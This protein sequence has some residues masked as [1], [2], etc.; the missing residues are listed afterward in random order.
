[1]PA[2][3]PLSTMPF[4]QES[5][6]VFLITDSLILI[7]LLHLTHVTLT[8]WYVGTYSGFNLTGFPPIVGS[9]L[10]WPHFGWVIAQIWTSLNGLI[11]KWHLLADR[12]KPSEEEIIIIFFKG[13][14]SATNGPINKQLDFNHGLRKWDILLFYKNIKLNEF[15][16]SWEG[17]NKGLSWDWEALGSRS[18]ISCLIKEGN[19]FIVP[20]FTL[21]LFDLFPFCGQIPGGFLELKPSRSRAPYQTGLRSGVQE[22]VASRMGFGGRLQ[23]LLIQASWQV[24]GGKSHALKLGKWKISRVSDRQGGSTLL[25]TLDKLWWAVF[26]CYVLCCCCCCC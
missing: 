26:L 3:P 18:L 21:F 7:T 2:L 14:V 12:R 22:N 1:M 23:Y 13:E 15:Q 11:P 5:Q 20:L 17:E 4:I 6:S 10:H 8:T 16:N 25:G 9:H 19:F 24:Q